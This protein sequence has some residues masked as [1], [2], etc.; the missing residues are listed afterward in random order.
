MSGATSA[1]RTD[2]EV[3]ADV[4]LTDEMRI[5]LIRKMAETK[6]AEEIS[7]WHQLKGLYTCEE[8]CKICADYRI[9]CKGRSHNG[10][11]IPDGFDYVEVRSWERYNPREASGDEANGH[12]G[13][14][15]FHYD[16]CRCSTSCNRDQSYWSCC[17]Q[18]VRY[19]RCTV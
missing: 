5:N 1:D 17:R 19:C 6:T 12:K 9:K 13:A 3:T 11:K 8:I 16:D 10:E 18:T 15:C 4:E 2:V 7:K 14:Y